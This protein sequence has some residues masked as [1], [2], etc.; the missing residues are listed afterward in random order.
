M[1]NYEILENSLIALAFKLID[2]SY[3][4]SEIDVWIDMVSSFLQCN[5]L[6]GHIAFFQID[7]LRQVF[8]DTFNDNF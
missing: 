3:S 6:L 5:Y 7:E 4:D 8:I 1:D 2:I